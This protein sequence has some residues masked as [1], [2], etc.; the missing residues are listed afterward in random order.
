MTAT[1]T[2]TSFTREPSKILGQVIGGESVFIEQDG[3]P[4]A[5]MIP[6]PRR[7]SGMDLA[8]RMRLLKPAPEAAEAVEALIKRMDDASRIAFD[9]D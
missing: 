2:A 5:V 9:T 4:C 7:T 1:A 6:H 3:E 8:C